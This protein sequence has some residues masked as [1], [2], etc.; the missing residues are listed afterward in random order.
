M[1]RAYWR[2]ALTLSASDGTIFS[3]MTHATTTNLLLT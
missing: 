2:L 3:T 1:G